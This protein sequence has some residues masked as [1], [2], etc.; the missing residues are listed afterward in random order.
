MTE[1]GGAIGHKVIPLKK[2]LWNSYI[3]AA[4]IPLLLIELTFLGIYWGTGEFVYDK[5]AQAVTEMS[6]DALSDAAGREAQ[7]ISRRLAT[8]EAL[9]KVYADATGQS[10]ERAPEA[11]DAE[12]ARYAYGPDGVFYTTENNG[13]SAVYFSGIVPVTPE[14]QDKVWR[15]AHL[16]PLMKS[17]VE[18]DPLI[19]QIYLNTYDSLNRIYPYFDVLEIFPPKMDI[20]SYN[21]YYEADEVHNPEGKVVWTDAYID[22]AGAGWMVSSIAPVKSAERLEAVVGIDITIS[23]IVEQVLDVSLAG[24]GYAM[25]VGRDGTILALPPQ[26]EKDLGLTELL[27]HR[28]DEA[29][30]DDTFK[31]SEFNIF[32]RSDLGGLALAMQDAE[33]GVMDLQ[34][35]H[36]VMASWSTV[37][38]PGWKLIAIANSDVLL[39]P[40]NTL[41][42]TLGTVSK[43]MLAALVIFYSI[44]FAVLWGRASKMSASVAQPLAELESD[45]AE[46]SA[47]GTLAAQRVHSVEELQNVNRHLVKMSA[48][49]SAASRAKSA[50][51]SAMSHELRTPLNAILGYTQL[52]QMAEGQK[53]DA[54][55]MADLEQ[56]SRSSTELLLLVEG[57]MDLSR[58]EQGTL[59]TS[60][61][62]VDVVPLIRHAFV[63][64]KPLADAK[65]VTFDL[66]VPHGGE[67]LALTDAGALKR[68]LS[69]LIS[70]AIKYNRDG[71]K[72]TARL[73]VSE[74]DTLWIDIQDTGVGIPEERQQDVFTPFERIGHENSSVSGA[75][76]GLSI[77]RRLIEMIRGH[78]TLTSEVGK[79]S[80]FSVQVPRP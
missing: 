24:E 25:L 52:L 44:Y 20:P 43:I 56:I 55:K 73:R 6:R 15:T 34:L 9:T 13:G 51:L 4:L 12:K 74:D 18:A 36:P 19:A 78:L 1:S 5:G 80:I 27:D 11:S 76:V 8:V 14:K 77:T 69:Q 29:I 72:V 47:G 38:G 53:I 49:L 35:E 63:A 54:T 41:R 68:I 33:S 79:G 60:F 2:W 22:P 42:T 23:N 46:I 21:F 45:M 67:T 26:G 17:I 31:P 59:D 37:A 66:D 32:R 30:L 39:Q 64:L 16:D 65:G 71:G 58:I 70:N 75:G 3:S 28:Y 10:L 40:S 57:V 48:K 7:T 61:E 50:F 62:A